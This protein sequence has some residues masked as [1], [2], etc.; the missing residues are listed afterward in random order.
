M[1]GRRGIDGRSLLAREHIGGVEVLRRLVW[2]RGTVDGGAAHGRVRGC[3]G[4]DGI[5]GALADGC[6]EVSGEVQ[7]ELAMDDHV[8]V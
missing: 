8:I 5:G 6:S 7:N 1:S 4:T 3:G 2:R